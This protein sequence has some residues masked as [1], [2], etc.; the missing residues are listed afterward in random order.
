MSRLTTALRR[1]GIICA[2]VGWFSSSVAA[3]P[4]LLST[5][6]SLQGLA[7]VE[8]GILEQSDAFET[9]SPDP[10]PFSSTRTATASDFGSRASAVAAQ[11][12]TVSSSGWSGSGTASAF[13]SMAPDAEFGSALGQAE[14]TLGIQFRLTESMFYR[15][16]GR[17]SEAEEGGGV[18]T[19]SFTG[20]D[21]DWFLGS[22]GDAAPLVTRSGLLSPGVYSFSAQAFQASGVVGQGGDS[23]SGVSGFDF[24]FSLSD[25]APVPEPATLVLFTTGAA[26]L[27]R[28]TWRRRTEKP[29]TGDSDS[30]KEA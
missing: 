17:L 22:N 27:G 26:F 23:R 13:A 20:P 11:N 1:T 29:A 25:Q 2:L 10:G 21:L 24:Q 6:R 8:M 3:D 16:S 4:I 18:A 14:S 7:L 9:G 15:F 28:T 5:G 30:I 19:V 12:T